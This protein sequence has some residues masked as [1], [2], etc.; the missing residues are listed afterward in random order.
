MGWYLRPAK[1]GNGNPGIYQPPPTLELFRLA[2]RAEELT[3]QTRYAAAIRP[4]SEGFAQDTTWLAGARMLASAYL[5]NG[6]MPEADSVMSLLEARRGRLAPGDALLLDL[7][8]TYFSSPEDEYRA[9]T[10]LIR[11]DSSQA[12]AA[13][14]AA[15]EAG[16]PADALR[17]AALRDTSQ[18]GRDWQLWDGFASQA[19]HALGRFEEELALARAA[20]AR[21]PRV[22]ALAEREAR[23]LAALG[24]M[25]DL[26]RL[27]NESYTLE[28][29]DAP[30]MLLGISA[31]ELDLH[32]REAEALASAERTLSTGSQLPDS[33][34]GTPG[35][36]A[37]LRTSL[38]IL[39]RFDE[40]RRLYDEAARTGG[41]GFRILGMRYTILMGDTAGAQAL[42][43]SARSGPVEAFYGLGGGTRGE[44][45]Y[46]GAH[47]L[48]LL[49][50]K[51]EAAGMLREAL[52]NGWRLVPDEELQWYWAPIKDYPPFQELVK[53]KDGS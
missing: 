25:D 18:S 2:D 42:A 10:A 37:V 46:Y 5:W 52:N 12:Y 47:V 43:D 45:M 51:Q 39:G 31:Q 8:R 48:A 17:F 44:A 23:A 33:V 30:T 22:Y 49:G 14:W 15:L 40:V 36:G 1:E 50:R 53:L 26:D 11:A 7:D 20:R 28:R 34:A 13:T 24:R 16:H 41:L 38:R 21:A 6:Q 32:G 9:A 35:V 29:L 19:Y 27:I 4:L 3:R